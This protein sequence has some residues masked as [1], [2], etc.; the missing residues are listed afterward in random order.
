MERVAHGA[1]AVIP[2]VLEVA[3]AAAVLVGLVLDLVGGLDRVDDLVG[4][5]LRRDG[6]AVLGELR[7]VSR[8]RGGGDGGA[9]ARGGGGAA[10]EREQRGRGQRGD[11]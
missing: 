5:V 1:R 6:G 10:A 7:L 8:D 9:P 11:G 4:R 2:L 3:V